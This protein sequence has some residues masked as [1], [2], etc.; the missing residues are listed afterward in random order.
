LKNLRFDKRAAICDSFYQ[1]DLLRLQPENPAAGVLHFRRS[2]PPPVARRNGPLGYP[3]PI[4][5]A[6]HK[7]RIAYGIHHQHP[8]TQAHQDHQGKGKA[9]EA[10]EVLG[11]AKT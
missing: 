1:S 7:F 11:P 3:P 9:E 2:P 10:E 4:D 5:W 6:A 8:Q